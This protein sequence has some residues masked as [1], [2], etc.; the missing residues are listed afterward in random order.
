MASILLIPI[1]NIQMVS[2]EFITSSTA[3]RVR[4]EPSQ[5]CQGSDR[6][7]P[8]L[9]KSGVDITYSVKPG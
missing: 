9:E 1:E 6:F 5:A 4:T 3:T 8:P 2:Q 7:I